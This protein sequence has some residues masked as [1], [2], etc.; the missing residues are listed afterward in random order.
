MHLR[1][2]RVAESPVCGRE[3]GHSPHAG[4]A[5]DHDSSCGPSGWNVP[6]DRGQDRPL[7]AFRRG[8]SLR[9]DRDDRRRRLPGRRSG[10]RRPR[11]IPRSSSSSPG[12]S[13]PSSWPR[14]SP[15]APRSTG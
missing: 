11:R 2:I 13:A 12:S 1:S 4:R 10:R 14:S 7:P 15:S 8:H 3:G 6:S 5:Y 9:R